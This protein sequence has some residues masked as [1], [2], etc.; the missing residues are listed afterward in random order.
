MYY[1]SFIDIIYFIVK[2]Y[3]WKKK[4]LTVYYETNRNGFL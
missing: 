3:K 1:V 2:R 4:E